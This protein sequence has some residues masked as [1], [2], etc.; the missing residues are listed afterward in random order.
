MS[1][2]KPL[3]TGSEWD[4]ELLNRAMDE[5]GIIA[6]DE[7]KLNC[8]TNQ[9]EVITSE[10]MLDA[11]ASI[12]LP[13]M[14]KHW[15]FGKKFSREMENYRS[16]KNGLA[17]EI[18]LNTQP[19]IAYLMEE[20][21]ACTQ[22]L[23]IAHAA[24]G[25]NHVF[26]NNYLF[27]QWTDAESIVDYLVFAKNYMMQ[28]EEKYGE[29]A[30]EQTLNAA[31]SLMHNGID[32]Y[33]RPRKLS[34]SEE[35]LKQ[36][37]RTEYL[38]SSV[39]SLW[40]SLLKPKAI[41]TD[42]ADEKFPVQPEE[43]ILYFLEKNSPILAPW[44][45]EILRIVRK[46]AQYFYPQGQCV[47]G[48][49]L[50]KTPDGLLRFDELIQ[51]DGYINVD[52]LQMLTLG[53]KYTMASHT[54]KHKAN[55]LQVKTESGKTFTGTP[56]HPLTI[57][58]EGEYILCK[59]SDMLLTDYIVTNLDYDIFS[60]NEPQLTYT[61]D[62]AELKC[63][64]C[65]LESNFLAS[66]ISQKHNLSINNYKTK[67]QCEVSNDIS[68]IKKSSNNLKKMP[69]M[70][71]PDVATFIAY[72]QYITINP[73][74]NSV[75]TFNHNN[76]EHVEKFNNL[77]DVLFGIKQ[78][79]TI[80]D[81]YKFKIEFSSYSLKLFINENF[82]ESI[83]SCSIIPKII[84]TSTKE[85]VAAYIKTVIDL[86]STRRKDISTFT[87]R[88]YTD[89]REYLEQLQTMLYGFGIVSRIKESNRNTI[90]GISKILGLENNPDR[91][92]IAHELYLTIDTG[93]K[94]LYEELIGTNL[95]NYPSYLGGSTKNNVIP[96]GMNLLNIVRK[97]LIDL[98]E[99]YAKN[100]NLNINYK[101]KIANGILVKQNFLSTTDIPEIRSIELTYSH[102]EK[103]RSK[104]HNLAKLNYIPEAQILLDLIEQSKGK[105]YDKIISIE[106]LDKEEYVY[107]V[108]IPENNLFWLDGNISHNTKM[109]NEGWASFTHYYIMNRLYDKGLLTDGAMLEF[110]KMHTGVVFQPAYD[111]PYYS[112]LN[113][114]YVGF[115]MFNDIKRICENPTVEDRELFPNIVDQP[116]V[117]VCLDVVANYRDESMVRQF[118]SPTLV[119]KLGL[120]KLS[121]DKKE[122]TYLID[123]IQDREG[124][125]QIRSSL[126]THYEANEW[127]PKIEIVDA[128]I[129][130][131][132]TL[133]LMYNKDR[134][135]AISDNWKLT[136]QHIRFLWGHKVKL[137]TKLGN[138]IGEC[139]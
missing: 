112:G 6:K 29:E 107:D 21:T 19:C 56:E 116:W 33:K 81:F 84:R 105:F 89:N 45:R 69:S 135:R 128:N 41:K 82:P 24:Y 121:D 76:L 70:M 42:Q 32:R 118:L 97:K 20:N 14:Y 80:S 108:T 125:K 15:S 98:R 64:L 17:Y 25:H 113:P 61:I 91:K 7:L 103:Y 13:V 87:L 44:Q 27:R 134:G 71:N 34:M 101:F 58:R 55:V 77:L 46:L 51:L 65:G 39:N 138:T 49:H 8:Y 66:H 88:T 131:D 129:K 79:V 2:I 74:N 10:Q 124:F 117:D 18:V 86:Y 28:C 133:I 53:N 83:T 72:I 93:S 99:E 119:R 94:K 67:Y 78:N 26:K 63:V 120:F 36:K 126:A 52:N 90:A 62:D 104:F 9:I 54:Y 139:S 11:Y 114:Y 123:A 31:H 122:E 111:S 73:D 110:V 137:I 85:S 57:L 50:I 23:V 102:V 136:L 68:R 30:V 92:L 3:F 5:C 127:H 12:G 132:R 35:K 106:N 60:L 43:N 115:E 100:A 16:G 38:E 37:E 95:I 75:F 47:T 48:N 40:S 22:V 1:N 4:F 59:L 96:N 109:L 130:G